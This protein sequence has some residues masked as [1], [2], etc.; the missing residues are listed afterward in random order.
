MMLLKEGRTE[1]C[2]NKLLRLE[3][4]KQ[5]KLEDHVK[6]GKTRMKRTEI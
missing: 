5:R 4:K 2:Q 6:D 1:E 3:W